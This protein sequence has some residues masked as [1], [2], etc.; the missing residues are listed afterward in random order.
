MSFLPFFY[1]LLF[2]LFIVLSGLYSGRYLKKE[3]KHY[4]IILFATLFFLIL[5]SIFIVV[6]FTQ[7]PR[8]F[9]IPAGFCLA[10]SLYIYEKNNFGETKDFAGIVTTF[11]IFTIIIL[12]YFIIRL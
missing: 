1:Y 3:N 4:T 12:P 8:L 11:S 6:A 9:I 10:I 7:N 5:G 2:G